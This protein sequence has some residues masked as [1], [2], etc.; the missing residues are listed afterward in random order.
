MGDPWPIIL[1][2]CLGDEIVNK[3]S[4]VWDEHAF[5]RKLVLP[6]E[7]RKTPW[8]GKGYRWFR[9]PN[10]IPLEQWRQHKRGEE[11][12]GASGGGRRGTQVVVPAA[13]RM[14]GP[15]PGCVS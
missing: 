11:E 9:S 1:L 12:P 15:P 4:P 2:S 14:T 13:F 3:E 8:E 6:Q 10:V 5:W 7:D